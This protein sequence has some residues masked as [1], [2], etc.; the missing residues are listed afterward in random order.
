MIYFELKPVYILT[1]VLNFVVPPLATGCPEIFDDH[2]GPRSVEER[3][4]TT[5]STELEHLFRRYHLL[6]ESY[7]RVQISGPQG[8]EGATFEALRRMFARLTALGCDVSQAIP[9]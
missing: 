8:D 5:G 3:A 4:A 7:S 6:S 9:R 2:T 1:L